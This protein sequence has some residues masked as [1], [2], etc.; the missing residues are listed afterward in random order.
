MF[1]FILVNVFFILCPAHGGVS[2]HL[3]VVLYSVVSS[4]HIIFIFAPSRPATHLG[5]GKVSRFGFGM[6]AS[7]HASHDGNL[8]AHGD[9]A[10]EHAPT[11]TKLGDN[12]VATYMYI[13]PTS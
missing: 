12:V 6:P 7:L 1:Y 11:M 9:N 2:D 4:V 10:T 13:N 3:T 8:H 5:T